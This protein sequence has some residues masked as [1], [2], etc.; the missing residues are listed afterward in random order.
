MIG[1]RRGHGGTGRCGGL[2]NTFIG[3][4][5]ALP[6][7]EVLRTSLERRA[8]CISPSP[9][10]DQDFGTSQATW[11]VPG[12]LGC[13]LRISDSQSSNRKCKTVLKKTKS[14]AEAPTGRLKRRWIA[15]SV[16][17]VVVA[18][19]AA[20][21]ANAQTQKVVQ[22]VV[23]S[24]DG[25]GTVTKIKSSL[26]TQEGNGKPRTSDREHDPAKTASKLPLRVLTSYRA[27]NDYGTDLND[28]KGKSGRV[29]IEITVQNT[30]VRPQML[31]YDS[32]AVGKEAPA[33]VGTPLTVMSSTVLEGVAPGEVVT[34]TGQDGAS[35]ID[36]TNGVVSQSKDGKTTVQ[37]ATM[38][39]PPR[40]ATSATFRLVVDASDMDVPTFDISAQPGMAADTSIDRLVNSVFSNEAGSARQIE[41]STIQLL[42]S[43]AVTLVESRKMLVDVQKLL[44]DQ[45]QKIGSK[46]I[47]D[48]QQSSS[49]IAATMRQLNS[50][51]ATLQQ[52]M[53]TRM[54][55]S[56]DEVVNT[57]RGVVAYVSSDVL[58]NS[59]ALSGTDQPLPQTPGCSGVQSAE[60][61]GTTVV[62]HVMAVDRQL[63]ALQVASGA[64]AS[65]IRQELAATLGSA[66]DTTCP[67]NPVTVF[68]SFA[69]ATSK[70]ATRI[71]DIATEKS[72]AGDVLET[73]ELD[74]VVS[75]MGS[76]V[77]SLQAIRAS[78]H[79]SQSN[80]GSTAGESVDGAQDDIAA[81]LSHLDSTGSPSGVSQDLSDISTAADDELSGRFAT[82]GTQSLAGQVA[83][84]KDGVC[85]LSGVSTTDLDALSVRL[86]GKKCDGNPGN[87]SYP[88][89]SD[90]IDLSRDVWTAT[91]GHATTGATSLSSAKQSLNSA[92][93]SLDDAASGVGSISGQIDALVA[94]GPSGSGGQCPLM[95]LAN[96]VQC[97]LNEFAGL[98]GDIKTN[99]E[100]SFDTSR[101]ALTNANGDLDSGKSKVKSASDN[102]DETVGQ[103]FDD[104]AVYLGNTRAGMKS[105]TR[106]RVDASVTELTRTQTAA[107]TVL[108]TSVESAL[109]QIG[110]LVSKSNSNVDASQRLLIADLKKVLVN[111]GTPGKAGSGL[112]GTIATGSKDMRA[113]RQKVG[114]ANSAVDGFR[115]IRSETLDGIRLQEKQAGAAIEAEAQYPAFDLQL[116]GGSKHAT[117]FSFRIGK[118]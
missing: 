60:T 82:S 57:L 86:T 117:V 110:K 102:A 2:L 69:C 39:A 49:E 44:D 35:P 4:P 46:T 95:L 58:G 25:N 83:D 87:G 36:G 52:T 12:D 20:T 90:S 8:R 19:V 21:V 9:C 97:D 109:D 47:G 54:N 14:D 94:A 77:T 68:Q 91:K 55:S 89:L 85:A 43:V 56:K 92:K 115:A 37:W 5:A 118:G 88:A 63:Q 23:V 96:R 45:A 3:Y 108:N 40:L 64:C 1:G 100:S 101:D 98:M 79:G 18:M 17:G 104:S 34:S 105:D 80:P 99:M 67:S 73:N 11:L 32:D 70:L 65:K 66:D 93:D 112:L 106:N 61:T 22:S 10:G 53:D 62:D 114:G 6:A 41:A 75:G 33:L 27:G 50:D 81:A 103:Y 74:S 16:I 31:Q 30:T 7:R 71:S 38:L 78:V 24:V 48:V 113:S 116:P 84:I 15:A 29:Q 51:V 13:V 59:A 26:V 76:L 42:G 28:L 111:I 107:T 72:Q